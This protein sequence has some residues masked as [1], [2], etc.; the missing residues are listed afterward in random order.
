M[1]DIGYSDS[2]RV[3]CTRIAANYVLFIL[4]KILDAK[5]K[6]YADLI[7]ECAR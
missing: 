4:G 6:N 2:H 5:S 3:C 7:T 1:A